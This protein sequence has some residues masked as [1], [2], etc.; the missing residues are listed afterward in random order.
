M[1]DKQNRR[2][3][4]LGPAAPRAQGSRLVRLICLV[5]IWIMEENV[6]LGIKPLVDCRHHFIRD[7]S[8][9]FSVSPL[10]SFAS[11]V[12]FNDVKEF[13]HVFI[14]KRKNENS[15][16]NLKY[17]LKVF[18]EYPYACEE[19]RET[20]EIF[21]VTPTR[22]SKIALAARKKNDEQY[23]PSS[24]RASIQSIDRRLRNNQ[25]WIMLI[26]Q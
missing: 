11:V 26:R 22:S 1:A 9:V 25:L 12:S 3:F 20:E 24:L 19:K 14:E 7:P 13:I 15:R 2:T 23:V 10:R 17:D 6:L 4:F 5:I 21:Y 18:R 8:G 16:K